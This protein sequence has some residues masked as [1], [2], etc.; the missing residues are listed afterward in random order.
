MQVL[1]GL[2]LAARRIGLNEEELGSAAWRERQPYSCFP[3]FLP[4]LP[5]GA[6]Y[7]FPL[8]A[9]LLQTF[10]RNMYPL[11]PTRVRPR[12]INR[13]SPLMANC[14]LCPFS[15]GTACDATRGVPVSEFVVFAGFISVLIGFARINANRV[16]RDACQL[17][18]NRM[19]TILKV[20]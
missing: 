3:C 1:V 6:A 19:P 4:Q 20:T 11:T 14:S 2:L 8:G 15:A 10:S 9:R 16:Q 7:L 5:R 18:A 13:I 17:I 12:A